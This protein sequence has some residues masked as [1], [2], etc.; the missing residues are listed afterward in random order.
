MMKSKTSIKTL[1]ARTAMTLALMLLTTATAWAAVG[2]VVDSGT[3]GDNL[4][5][6]LAE[7]GDDAVL[8]LTTPPA[9]PPSH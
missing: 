4:T 1:A 9:T 3:C 2:D 8:G 7:N 5:W 6:T